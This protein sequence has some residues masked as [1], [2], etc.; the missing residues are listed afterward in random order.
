MV[1]LM[2]VFCYKL[3]IVFCFNLMIVFGF[4]LMIVFYRKNDSSFVL[5]L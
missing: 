5:Y 3:M 2:I 4:T 1:K